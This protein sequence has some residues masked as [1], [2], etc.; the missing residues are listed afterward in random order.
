MQIR[1]FYFH[2]SES[3]FC[4][5]EELDARSL[6]YGGKVD[7]GGGSCHMAASDWFSFVSMDYHVGAS[8]RT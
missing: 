2:D 7:L 4:R 3:G 1:V 5:C 8:W 6:I